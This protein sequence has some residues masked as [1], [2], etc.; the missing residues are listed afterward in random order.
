MYRS[1]D[2]FFIFSGPQVRDFLE[3]RKGIV[4]RVIENAPENDL[5]NVSETVYINFLLE[6]YGIQIPFIDFG[7]IFASDFEARVPSRSYLP[8]FDT[9]REY[10]KQIILYHLPFTPDGETKLFHYAA[11]KFKFTSVEVCII[12]NCICFE[13]VNYDDN[14]DLILDQAEKNIKIIREGMEALIEDS[15][16]HVLNR[17]FI[18]QVLHT[19]KQK[20]LKNKNLLASL[21]VPLKKSENL[22]GTYTIP[23]PSNRKP[24]IVKPVVTEREFKP[25]PTISQETYQEI[26]QIIHDMGKV[27]EFLPATYINKGEEDLRDHLLLQLAPR[28]KDEGSVTGETFSKVGKTDILYRY[29]NSNAFVAECKFWKGKNQYL[30]TISQLLSY[31]I[32]RDSKAAVVMFVKN[33]E[34]SSVLE[35]VKQVTPKHPNYLDFVDEQDISWLNYRFHINNDPNREVKLAVMLYHI[36]SEYSGRVKQSKG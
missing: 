16:L 33:K 35:T 7:G 9:E 26:L 4:Q 19:R 3:E 6:Q 21:N 1:L 27:F 30:D 13:I 20:L 24:L 5:L 8:G 15:N 2:S 12:D 10:T 28:F 17:A 22:P 23:T 14:R 31:L 36:P 11:S 32:W 18:E 25:E 34:I 29:Q